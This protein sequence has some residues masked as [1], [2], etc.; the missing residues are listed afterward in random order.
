M[1]K[2]ELFYNSEA[3]YGGEDYYVFS[4]YNFPNLPDDGWEKWSLPIGNGYMGVNV[5][6]RTETERL[7]ITENS[8]SNPATYDP[9]FKETYKRHPGIIAGLH[10]FCETYIDFGHPFKEVESYRRSLSLNDGIAKTE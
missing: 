1:K 3:P 5:F 10:N 8:F 6:G 2:Y 9:E 7:Q 4:H